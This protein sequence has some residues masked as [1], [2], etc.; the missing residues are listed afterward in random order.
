VMKAAPAEDRIISFH[1]RSG[2][3]DGECL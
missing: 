2:L 3:G 1:A